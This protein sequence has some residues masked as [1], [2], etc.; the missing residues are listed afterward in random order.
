MDDTKNDKYV[1]LVFDDD[2]DTWET[3]SAEEKE[4]TFQVDY[5]F[6]ELLAKRGGQVVG[7][8]GLTHSRRTRWLTRDRGGQAV[9]TDGPYAETVEQLVGFFVVESPDLET[10]TEACHE[11]LPAHHRLEIRPVSDD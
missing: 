1:V 10:V 9:V 6:G 5:R 2:E 11:M 3:L 8:A 7:G 4:Q